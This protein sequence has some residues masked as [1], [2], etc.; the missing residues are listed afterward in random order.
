MFS[1]QQRHGIAYRTAAVTPAATGSVMASR[2]VE[3]V[4][5]EGAAVV[6]ADAVLTV[7]DACGPEEDIHG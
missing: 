7:V 3:E 2:G 6:V 1:G 5:A 4:Q